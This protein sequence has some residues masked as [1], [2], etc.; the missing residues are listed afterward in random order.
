MY[1]QHI[2]SGCRNTVP[3]HADVAE[4]YPVM[5]AKWRSFHKLFKVL[6]SVCGQTCAFISTGKA[7]VLAGKYFDCE[8]DIST[9][10]AAGKEGLQGLYDL[11][12]EFLGGLPNDGGTALAIEVKK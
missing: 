1:I 8:Q 5:A 10:V 7:K 3:V 11:K 12:V 2:D 6:P 4:R 9:V